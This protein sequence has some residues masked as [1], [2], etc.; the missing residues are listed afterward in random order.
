MFRNYLLIGIRSLFKHRFYTIINVAGLALGLSASLLLTTWIIHE[1]SYDKFHPLGNR[2]YRSSL[3]YSFGGQT[4]KTAVSPT[5]LLPTL[6][7]NFP[8]V[9][10][11]VRVYNSSAYRPYLVRHEHKVFQEGR[12]S[13]AD[14]TFFQLF[15][16][17][18]LQGDADKALILPNSVVVTASAAKKY[19]G[20]EDPVGKTM[21]VNNAKDYI[22]TGVMADVPTNSILQFDFLASFSSLDAAKEQIW[23][24]ANYETFVLLTPDADVALLTQKT[25]DIVKAALASELTNPGD[26]V[27]YNFLPL[28]DIYLRSDMLESRP[29][30]NIQYIYIFGGIALLV[31]VIA[32]INYI[33]LATARASER[34]KEVGVRKVVGAARY[35]L[36]LQFIGES[37]IITTVSLVIALL[38]ARLTI[39]TFN[40]LTGKNFASSLIFQPSSIALITLIAITIA[41]T[42]GA[43]PALAIT[44]FK[45]VQ[46]LKG[47]FKTS[48]K[49]I[50]LRK[51]L[52][53]FQFCI[54]VM[55][56]IG[57][58]VVTQ[59]LD[60]I[61]H[62]KLG[63]ERSNV[64]V[65]PMDSKTEAVYDQLKTEVLRSGTATH[66]TRATE[67]PT[68]IG[69]G[70]SIN[71]EGSGNSRGMIVTAMSVDE[72]FVP[73]LKIE[74]AAGRNFTENDF[75][76]AAADTVYSF[77]LNESALRE[78]TFTS[79]KAIGQRIA[80]NG[81]K[82]EIVGIIKD[83]HFAPLHKKI[84]PLVFFNQASDYGYIFITLKPG[85][86]A[87][88]LSTLKQIAQ[89]IAPHR[90]FDYTF[91]DEEYN[92]LYSNEQRMG[93]I[94][95]A[96]AVLTIAIAC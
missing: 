79:D 2:I 49:G 18:L 82:G 72:D 90:P 50:W 26:Y 48:G 65:L 28:A 29:V 52:V 10:N 33:N 25:E 77:I 24:S 94:I 12:F 75:R 55:L 5:A 70:Y 4:S 60:F 83:F 51:M 35:Q 38:I 73:A 31:L 1:L 80:M 15:S 37:V 21:Q 61:Q 91:L 74:L 8:E 45:P 58:L 42:A 66:I 13:Y 96:F 53:V 56:I 34:A 23:W 76:K 62:K 6:Q 20:D 78:L 95:T 85:N 16:F 63:Y 36:F 64:I 89:N 47:Q 41:I 9:E 81:R 3:E 88:Y 44:S 11:G 46:V 27:K 19:F 87:T 30:S 22:V 57:T 14:S 68:S 71:L 39:P 40:T 32:C 59:Q 67:S 86:P 54:S 69:A 92:T 43:Y 84:A 17:P 93:K 7:K